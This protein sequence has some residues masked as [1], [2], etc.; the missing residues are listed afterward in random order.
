MQELDRL[1]LP[2]SPDISSC[3]TTK[4]IL[5]V[6]FAHADVVNSILFQELND[7]R[8]KNKTQDALIEKNTNFRII[9]MAII[10][11]MGGLIT[12]SLSILGL[13]AALKII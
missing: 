5:H 2:S 6:M 12:V 9:F 1:E 13:L 3:K 8:R 4:E 10:K 11:I 7:N